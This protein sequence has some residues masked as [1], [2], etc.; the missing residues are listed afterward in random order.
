M[1]GND[2]ASTGQ[3]VVQESII[4]KHSQTE[5]DK[6]AA[7]EKPKPTSCPLLSSPAENIP[8]H[9]SIWIAVEPQ[10]H[11]HEDAQSFPIS[12]RM[13]ALHRHGTLHR[14]EDGAI[15]FWRLKAESKTAFP[16]AVHRSILLWMDHLQKGGG[17]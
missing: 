11:T 10:G 16:N 12:K 7:K 2:S 3:L 5:A 8:T 4:V 9:E 13:I 15:D 14:D 17:H 6:P 1:T